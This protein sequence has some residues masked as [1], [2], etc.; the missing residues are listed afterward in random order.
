MFNF[1]IFANNLILHQRI[2]NRLHML[3]LILII[4]G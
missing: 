4:L 2:L 1:L 3:F